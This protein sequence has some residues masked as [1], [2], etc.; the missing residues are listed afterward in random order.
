M[1]QGALIAFENPN[2]TFDLYWSHNGADEFYLRPYLE[3][4]VNGERSRT[5]PNVEP[6]LPDGIEVESERF[7]I[8]DTLKQAIVPEPTLRGVHR[9]NVG[10][11][12]DFLAYDGFYLVTDQGVELY[13]P[14]WSYPGIFIALRE[15]IDLEVYSRSQMETADESEV[16][17]VDPV[18]RFSTEDY[19]PERFEDVRYRNFLDL[20]HLGIFQ[21]ISGQIND[22]DDD[23][24]LEPRTLV[25][26]E[27][28]N[29]IPTTPK[30]LFEPY[31]VGNGVLIQFA[32]KDGNLS[33]RMDSVRKRAAS[34]RIDI[35]LR[36][37]EASGGTPTDDHYAHFERELV[38]HAYR[39][40]GMT[41]Y[42]DPIQPYT[43]LIE[44]ISETYA[45]DEGVRGNEY[46]VIDTDG[47]TALFK[48]T[49]QYGKTGTVALSELSSE[50]VCIVDLTETAEGYRGVANHVE[51][52]DIV[53]ADINSQETESRIRSIQ[54]LQKIPVV[55][56]DVGVAPKF[57]QELYSDEVDTVGREDKIP[58]VRTQLNSEHETISD[59]ELTI[60]E[61]QVTHDPDDT[62]WEGL[63]FG[64]ISEQVYGRFL[65]TDGRPQEV[66][67]CNPISEPYWFGFFFDTPM[68]GSARYWR[69]QF[70]CEYDTDTLS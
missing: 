14:M 13:Y 8:V 33:R 21:T 69:R 12:L 24:D 51:N 15:M 38:E 40:F 19:T 6:K 43:S 28:V 27:Y 32:L 35:S 57:V 44:E 36:L 25:Q 26:E 60:G 53:I 47:Q 42:P 18:A 67:L 66:L 56:T 59:T 29:I 22:A 3:D 46:R 65:F 23:A 17:Q 63:E 37:L 55:M 41:I 5:L 64:E 31:R 10:K 11:N 58:S 49:E 62:V 68:T 54:L 1:S 7:E 2:G 39:H 34:L 48:L 50:D 20:H 70:A 45:P 4:V 61:V 52:G 30:N 16:D 9:T